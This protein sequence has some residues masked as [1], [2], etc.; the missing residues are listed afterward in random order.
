MG[1]FTK[2]TIFTFVIRVFN[3]VLATISSI[4]V[5]RSLGPEGKGIY[6]AAVLLPPLLLAFTNP[7]IGSAAVYFIGRKKYSPKEVFGSHVV[8]SFLNS[9]FALLVGLIIIFFFGNKF[10]PNIQMSYL[11]LGLFLTPLHIFLNSNLG[12]LLALQKIRKYNLI[13]FIQELIYLLAVAFL[14]LGMSLGIKTI[15]IVEFLSFFIACAVLF[16][17][18]KREAGGISFKF[19]KLYFRESLSYGS[20]IYLA[21]VLSFFRRRADM[22]FVNFFLNP[23][24]LGFYS[25][26]VAL[27]EKILL[28]AQSSGIVLFPRVASEDNK[29][30][31]KQFTPLV[32]RNT[33]FITFVVALILFIFSNFL[34]TIFYSE[35]FSKS[36]NPFKILLFGMVAIS[37]VV[38]LSNDISGRGKPMIPVYIG[39][40]PI[41]TN[42]ILDI[43]WIPKWGIEGAAWA[44]L[45]ADIL[46]FIITVLV[47][48]KISGNRIRDV[49]FI[50][51]SDFK[52]YKNFLILFKNK[53]FNHPK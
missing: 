49:I 41:T 38:A 3:L 43:L 14:L 32:C 37:G 48:S 26:A 15:I 4:I 31:L 45:I 24:A 50:K 13:S 29:V 53:Y 2:D 22:F 8:F 1:K 47:Y 35:V 16:L 44:L 17:W 18:I 36:I 20:K 7:G 40:V 21:G 25:I 6:S 19:N 34:I 9:I 33:L 46:L 42:I 52:Y 10:F 39:I 30:R 51:K 11:I 5:A 27:S 28:I 12:I 23:T